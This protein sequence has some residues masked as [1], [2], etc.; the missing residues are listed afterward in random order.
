MKC[1]V[2][3]VALAAGQIQMTLDEQKLVLKAH[4]DERK[5]FNLPALTW[6]DAAAKHAIT[7]ATENHTNKRLKHSS[8]SGF[9]EN[10]YMSSSGAAFNDVVAMHGGWLGEKKDWKTCSKKFNDKGDTG[11]VG[12]YTAMIWETTTQVG[13]AYK[14]S[15]ANGTFFACNY[16]PPGNMVGADVFADKSQCGTVDSSLAAVLA[17]G[18]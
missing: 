2:T 16:S 10:I 7:V 6:S 11:V 9:G 8:G 14:A 12:H 4:N 17:G 13:C 5:K 18:L 1:A 15:D 3:L